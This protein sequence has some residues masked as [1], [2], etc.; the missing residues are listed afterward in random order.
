MADFKLNNALSQETWSK[1]YMEEYT[2]TSGFLPYMGKG[3]DAVIRI[4]SD[5]TK[6]AGDVINIPYFR[7]LSGDGV[8]GGATLKGNEEALANYDIEVRISQLRNG[9]N[10]PESQAYKT[11]LQ[12]ANI[13]GTSLRSWSAAKLKNSVCSALLSVPVSGGT[14]DGTVNPDSTVDYASA[15]EAQKDAYNAA[16]ADRMVFG[17]STATASG[18]HSADLAGIANTEVLTAAVLDRAKDLAEATSDFRITPFQTK[19]TEGQEYFVFFTNTTG[20]NQLRADE[21]IKTNMQNAWTRDEM[22]NPVFQG[23]DLLHNGIIIRKIPELV[24]LGNVGATSAAVGASFLCGAGAAAV[25]WGAMP[26]VRTQKDDYGEFNG[27]A[28][29]EVRGVKKMTAAL[30]DLGVVTVYHA[31]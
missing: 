23:G 29:R 4:D 1:K 26:E 16:N 14:T 12:L 6:T 11:D 3:N 25:A 8:S 7:A 30:H 2:R 31:V 20:Y 24:G 15:T 13:A 19:V 28:I 27:L 17:S 18:D 22:K 21:E 5:L 10:I 9:V